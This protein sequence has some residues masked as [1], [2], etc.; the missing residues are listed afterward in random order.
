MPIPWEVAM[1]LS[2]LL[3]GGITILIIAA[4][5]VLSRAYEVAQPALAG[6]S[7]AIGLADPAAETLCGHNEN[8][9]ATTQGSWQLSTVSAL[10]DAEELLDYLECQ[11]YSE[12]ELVILGNSTFAV[13]WR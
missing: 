10:C 4:S 7:T 12:R 6:E 13:R 9:I 8:H 2:L 3:I 5:V 1:T 11:G